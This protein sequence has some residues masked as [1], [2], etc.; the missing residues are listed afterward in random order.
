MNH[1]DRVR[2]L[3][4]LRQHTWDDLPSEQR[5]K[6]I[7]AAYADCL[8]AE[9]RAVVDEQIRLDASSAKLTDY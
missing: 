3:E 6:I 7:S 5:E 9:D 1:R 2:K 4:V 8:T